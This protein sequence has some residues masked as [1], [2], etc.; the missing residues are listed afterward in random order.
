MEENH[1]T[2]PTNYMIQMPQNQAP[3]KRL[4]WWWLVVGLISIG[5]SVILGFLFPQILALILLTVLSAVISKFADR[6]IDRLFKK[7]SE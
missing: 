6:M 3:K 2:T 7:Q 4:H 5:I 1:S